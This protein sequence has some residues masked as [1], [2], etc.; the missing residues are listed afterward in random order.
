MCCQQLEAMPRGFPLSIGKRQQQTALNT[1]TAC[2]FFR[3]GTCAALMP[4]ELL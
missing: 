4:P 1:H 3:Y 2:G